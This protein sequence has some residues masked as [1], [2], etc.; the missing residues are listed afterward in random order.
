M[1][2]ALNLYIGLPLPCGQDDR[3]IQIGG[4]TLT[5]GPIILVPFAGFIPPLHKVVLHVGYGRAMHFN[6]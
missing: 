5:P 4:T 2:G 6:V 3:E 1:N